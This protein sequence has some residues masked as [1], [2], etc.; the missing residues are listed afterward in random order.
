M[1]KAQWNGSQ[2]IRC[3]KVKVKN[4][5]QTNEH[6][7]EQ[8]Q[9]EQI[10]ALTNKTNNNGCNLGK[11][12]FDKIDKKWLRANLSYNNQHRQQKGATW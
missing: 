7:N 6:V 5:G 8:M 3:K 10:R 1:F 2:K 9:K 4:Q 12:L 11:K